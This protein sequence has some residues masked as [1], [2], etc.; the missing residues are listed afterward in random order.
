MTDYLRTVQYA[1]FTVKKSLLNGL[2]SR[3]D[4]MLPIRLILAL[5]LSG[6]AVFG[7]PLIPIIY[8]K[9]CCDLLACHKVVNLL[10]GSGSC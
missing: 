1:P 10:S 2:C 5:L 8:R 6:I 4:Q 3:G 9:Q 7:S